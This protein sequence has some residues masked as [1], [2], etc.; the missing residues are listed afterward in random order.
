[1][2]TMSRKE[3]ERKIR[4]EDIINAAE[5]VFFSKGLNNATMDEVANEAE[6]SK[7]TIYA[8]FTSKEQI[9][10]AIISRAYTILN[11]LFEQA[12]KNNH[13]A[14]GF[15]K[16]MLMGQTYLDFINNYPKYF[17][18]MAYYENQDEDLVNQDEFKAANYQAGNIGSDLLIECIKEG[19]ADG[20]IFKELDPVS[21]AFVLYAN[22]IGIG[23]LILR[24]EKYIT[25]TYHKES[26]TLISGM[27]QLITRGLRPGF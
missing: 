22:I 12:F 3:Q 26:A 20:S 6:Y 24:K 14:N 18:A 1:M 11:S 19:I 23:N 2:G 27:Y 17:E 15:E 7:R 4:Y 8:Y 10:D 25:H 13:P 5:K 16:V 9:Y 21:T